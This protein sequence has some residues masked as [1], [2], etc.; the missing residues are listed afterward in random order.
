MGGE[1]VMDTDFLW[2]AELACR[3]AW[4]AKQE[5]PLGGW[6]ARHSGGSIRR[7]N[8]LN[9]LPGSA[10]LDDRLIDQAEAHYARFNQPAMVRLISFAAG[11]TDALFRRGYRQ[12][13]DTT[14]L[15][16]RLDR[17]RHKPEPDVAI[18]DRPTPA[19]LAA[20]DRIAAS[21]SSIF[22]SMLGRIEGPAL[23][24][25]AEADGSL[26]SVCYGA[27]VNRLLVVESVA[28]AETH[29]GKGL[30]RKAVGALMGWAAS[31]G[32]ADAVL[33]VVTDNA[34][35]RAL[36]RTLGFGTELFDY[37]YMRQPRP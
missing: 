25:A 11:S 7:V 28:T 18:S 35:A 4:P 37:V 13:G 2:R 34:P 32:I 17:F 31:Q 3:A 15:R 5:T 9:Q 8:S 23:F 20:R 6:L 1:R 10:P 36:Y 26:Q 24:S 16:A 33:Q 27:I 14:T 22:R 29:R 21:D 19:W 30:A 12:E